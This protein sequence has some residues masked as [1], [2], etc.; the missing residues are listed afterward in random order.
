M[1]L[2]CFLTINYIYDV[3]GGSVKR[4]MKKIVRNSM[5]LFNFI[6]ILSGCGMKE[7]Q[8]VQKSTDKDNV[9]IDNENKDNLQHLFSN[10]NEKVKEV[11]DASEITAYD[12]NFRMKEMISDILSQKGEYA[13]KY[14][15]MCKEIETETEKEA[16]EYY[17]SDI[18]ILWW[19]AIENKAVDH[20]AKIAVFSDKYELLG[21]IDLNDDLEGELLFSFM[22]DDTFLKNMEE[23]PKEKYLFILNQSKML[24]L[25]E[26]NE[27]LPPNNNPEVKTQ[28]DYYH[29]LPYQTLAVSYN[30]L[31]DGKHFMK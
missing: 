31:A 30:D 27:I 7:K 13:Q 1:V 25:N 20:Y 4:I 17:I 28:E 16:G 5:L 6:I 9:V 29:A 26:N 11:L 15:E 19:D 18:P 12:D 24:M 2:F 21:A 23:A 10:E 22:P 8:T 3:S 14:K